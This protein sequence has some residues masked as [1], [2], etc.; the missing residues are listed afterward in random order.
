MTVSEFLKEGGPFPEAVPDRV[1]Y[2][3]GP[4]PLC[5]EKAFLDAGGEL[6]CM[7]EAHH[8]GELHFDSVDEITWKAGPPGA[9][10]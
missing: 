1:P 4:G 10:A 6:V 3:I 8:P 5:T 7:L 2:P 9:P